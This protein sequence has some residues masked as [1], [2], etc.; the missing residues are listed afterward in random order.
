MEL[1][2]WLPAV[3]TVILIGVLTVIRRRKR[4]LET[5]TEEED[6]DLIIEDCWQCPFA[7]ASVTFK[8]EYSCTH[9]LNPNKDFLPMIV[10]AVP[11][12]CPL[13]QEPT[14]VIFF[15]REREDWEMEQAKQQEVEI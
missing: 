2:V 4:E 15:D 10:G 7:H 8:D 11:K 9:G 3:L 14:R 6:T 1:Y 5:F 12:D 13:R